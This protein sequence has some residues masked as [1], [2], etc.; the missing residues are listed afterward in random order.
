ME[1]FALLADGFLRIW[2]LD[3]LLVML[4]AIPFGLIF[5]IVPGLSGLSALAILLP[6]TYGME[7]LPGLA[8]LLAAHAVVYTGGSVTAIVLGIPGSPPNAATVLDGYP[9]ARNGLGG[10]AIGAALASS[11]LGGLFGVLVLVAVLPVLEPIVLLFGSPET[12][13]LAVMGITFIAVVGEGTVEKGLIAGLLGIFLALF[14]YQPVTSVPRFYFDSDYLLDGFRIIPL[15][16]G[17][18]AIPEIVGLSVKGR[19]V[20]QRGDAHVRFSQV[21]EGVVA[22]FR[23]PLLFLKSS[24]IGAVVGVVPGVGGETAPF[25]AYAAA[26]QSSRTPETFGSGEIEGVIAPESANNAK[27]GG[28]LVPTLAFGIP[29]SAGMAILLGGFLILGLEPGPEFMREH[30]DLGVGLAMVLAFA[31]VAAAAVMILFAPWIARITFLRG[32][33]L[34]PLLLAV[35]VLGTFASKN[36]PMD[37]VYVFVFGA[38]GYVMKIL[39]YSRAPLILGFVLTGAMETYLHISIR[40]YGLFFFTRP[41]SLIII[42]LLVLGLGWPF[43]KRLFARWR[44]T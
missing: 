23:H 3:V 15:A 1:Y 11:G 12:F 10:R 19:S 30:M 41:I 39:G 43:F 26:K 2:R 18:F 8:L 29:G 21:V 4:A 38:L 7:P 32:H 44:R 35:V 9:M 22:V 16:L 6:F 25:V 14:G 36:N 34:A 5:G 33:V 13:L 31:N 28:A 20:A 17:L 27:E 37:V 24:A 40:T 42:A